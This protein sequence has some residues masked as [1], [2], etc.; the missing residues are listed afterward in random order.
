MKKLALYTF[1]LAIAAFIAIPAFGWVPPGFDP[2]IGHMPVI[3]VDD[4]PVVIEPISPITDDI[5]HPRIP[6]PGFD[7]SGGDSDYDGIPN[8]SDNCPSVANADQMDFDLDGIGDVCDD[9][10]GDSIMDSV[11]NCRA[12]A[13]ADQADSNSD[14]VGDACTNTDSDGIMDYEDNCPEDYNPLQT[15]RDEDGLGDVCDN[16]RMVYNPLQEDIDDDGV[17]DVCEMDW[18]G[19]GV[20]DDEDNCLLKPNS[21]QYDLDEDGIGDV[22]DPRCDGPNC[23]MAA[24]APIEDDGPVSS[25][26]SCSLAGHAAGS[27][28]AVPAFMMIVF[29][30]VSIASGRRKIK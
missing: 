3:P 26:E 24:I 15:D 13:N 21:D 8:T 14:G 1:I 28:S 18:D 16:C 20:I 6:I 7:P 17:G 19:D 9:S 5:R 30:V 22:C 29:A 4:R 2:G 12:I 25:G 11:D 27:A 10:D 23:P